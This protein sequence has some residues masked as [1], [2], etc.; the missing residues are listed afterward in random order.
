MLQNLTT[1]LAVLLERIDHNLSGWNQHAVY[2]KMCKTTNKHCNINYKILSCYQTVLEDSLWQTGCSPPRTNGRV[3]NKVWPQSAV[4]LSE[5]RLVAPKLET[6]NSWLCKPFGVLNCS[7]WGILY[8]IA[9]KTGYLFLA[10]Q[11]NS[12]VWLQR[13]KMQ[14]LFSIRLN[15]IVP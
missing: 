1:R 13:V 4:S 10:S 11:Q 2:E 3:H 5:S 8:N 14:P 9:G 7:I 15:K 12:L 6:L